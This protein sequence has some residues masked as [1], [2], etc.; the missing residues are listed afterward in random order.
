MP[1]KTI[2]VSQNDVPVFEAAQQIAG[3]AMSSVIAKAL[4]EY[5]ARHHEKSKGMKEVSV[6]I[7]NKEAER[8]QRFIAT[9]IG[10]WKGVSDDKQWW[11]E[12]TIYHTQKGNWAVFMDY[13]GKTMLTRN[14]WKD[15]ETWSCNHCHTELVV[16]EHEGDWQG[17]LPSAL[18]RHI[19]ALSEREQ[20][21]V[22]YLDI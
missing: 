10:K 19:A 20:N 2:Y 18:I 15:P 14:A 6:K 12:A 4:R 17:K 3:E 8:E 9:E 11:I 21:P 7:G 5:V 13:K 22:D 16:A 1:N